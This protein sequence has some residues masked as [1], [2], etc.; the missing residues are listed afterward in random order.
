MKK[1]IVFPPACERFQGGE[2][3][4]SPMYVDTVRLAAYDIWHEKTA[5]GRVKVFIRST[6]LGECNGIT[7][8]ELLGP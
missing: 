4:V 1:S 3:F 7:L 5:M 8:L 6:S 2:N